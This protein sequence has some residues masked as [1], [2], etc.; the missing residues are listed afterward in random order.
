MGRLTFGYSISYIPRATLVK[1]LV[2]GVTP[3]ASQQVGG[4][5][6]LPAAVLAAGRADRG[7]HSAPRHRTG[8]SR[9]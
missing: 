3:L 1:A 4:H 9:R 8:V 5:E 2:G 7:P 6:L